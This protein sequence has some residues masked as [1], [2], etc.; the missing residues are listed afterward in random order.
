MS[1]DTPRTEQAEKPWPTTPYDE[2]TGKEQ[3]E[4]LERFHAHVR[5]LNDPKVDAAYAKLGEQARAHGF[6]DDADAG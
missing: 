2:M 4:F 1:K 3:A 6:S 5:D